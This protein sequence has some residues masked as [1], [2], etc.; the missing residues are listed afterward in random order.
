[1]PLREE[2]RGGALEIASP[3]PPELPLSVPALLPGALLVLTAEGSARS[4][5]PFVTFTIPRRPVSAVAALVAGAALPPPLPEVGRRRHAGS[6]LREDGLAPLG[7][8]FP[9]LLAHLVMRV[10]SA[11]V[12]E[13]SAEQS[14]AAGGTCHPGLLAAYLVAAAVNSLS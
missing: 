14:G 3:L 11:Q 12:A 1:M 4:L 5:R 8:A 7:R 13:P 9:L 2:G 6:E 10:D